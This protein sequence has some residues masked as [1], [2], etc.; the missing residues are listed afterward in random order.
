[1]AILLG[2][3]PSTGSFEIGR[4]GW[5]LIVALGLVAFAIR[6]FY[7]HT[8]VVDMP[9]RGDA[10]SYHAY[11][12]NLFHH[13]VF[14]KDLQSAVP[15]PDSY[16]DPGFPLLIAL[17]MLIGGPD[18]GWY[19]ALLDLQALLGAL[20]V[21][22][23]VLA[24]RHLGLSLPSLAVAGILMAF[25]PHLVVMCGYILTETL[26]GFLVAAAICA[27]CAARHRKWPSWTLAGLF[28]GMA[29]L[30][31][32]ILLPFGVLLAVGLYVLKK[33]SWKPAFALAL[34]AL[35][36]PGA[37]MVRGA[38]LEAETSALTSTSSGRA[39]QNLV[40]GAWPEYHEV[41]KQQIY[42]DPEAAKVMQR[43]EDEYVLMVDDPLRGGQVML[44]RLALNPVRYSQ[45][46]LYKPFL[47]WSWDVRIGAGGPVVFPVARSAYLTSPF[48]N[49]ISSVL[50]AVNP[51]M[52]FMALATCV[53]AS[54]RWRVLEPGALTCVGMFLYVTM[55]YSILQ[56]EPRYSIPFKSVEILLAVAMLGLLVRG[57]I[58]KG[59]VGTAPR[60]A[61]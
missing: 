54:M 56:S 55:V 40:Q 35:I 30:T 58:R 43:I 13:G 45:W 44:G 32:A 48:F 15:T 60:D 3:S 23:M 46:Y 34:G 14:S 6:I 50:K 16:R 21:G 2:D 31:N 41:W 38:M 36:L 7:V 52:F 22:L 26:M 17:A 28:F 49:T 42:G 4:S 5:I 57:L 12:Q 27:V 9:I 11:A 1:M 37:W 39:I 24:G 29:S 61:R 33:I 51:F 20:T 8:T 59:R 53:L 25:W 19:T 10:V 18:I 47:L